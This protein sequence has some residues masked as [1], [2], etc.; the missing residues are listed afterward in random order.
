MKNTKT[1]GLMLLANAT[2]ILILTTGGYAGL[3]PLF[4]KETAPE[5]YSDPLPQALILTSIAWPR[6]TSMP[7]GSGVA[8]Q[9]DRSR[10]PPK[11]ISPSRRWRP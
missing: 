10:S 2:N 1:L 5:A 7:A 3:A 8:L 6:L 11:M 9:P 4:T